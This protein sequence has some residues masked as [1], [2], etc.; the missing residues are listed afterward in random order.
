[1]SFLPSAR[2]LFFGRGDT[3]DP[4]LGEIA[5]AASLTELPSATSPAES[6]NPLAHRYAILGYPDDDG[7]ALNG[8]RSGAREAPARIRQYLYKMTPPA[9]C[10]GPTSPRAEQ[11]EIFDFGDL[12]CLTL[13]DLEIRHARAQ[14]AVRKLLQAGFK[15]ISFGGGHDYGFPDAAAFCESCS[16]LARPIVINFDAHLDVRPLDKGPHSGTPFRRLLNHFPE[17]DFVELGLQSHCNSS[18]HVRWAQEKGAM[19]SF[20]EDRLASGESLATVLNRFLGEKV[21]QK[22][23]AFLS[24]DIDGFSS[25]IAPGASQVWPTGFGSEDFFDALSWCLHRLNVWGIGIYEVS[26]KFDVDD[27]TSRLAAL[28][29]HRFMFQL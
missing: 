13:K 26:P 28:I 16:G 9:I 19:L 2:Q 21:V 10:A 11:P 23:P 22:R 25:A 1:M 7:I 12:D 24:I 4:R 3:E 15:T 8:G 20:Q 14:E 18:S 27:R 17:L 29:A 5:K 6:P